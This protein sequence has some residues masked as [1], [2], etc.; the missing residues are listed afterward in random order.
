[1]SGDLSEV[2]SAEPGLTLNPGL[3]SAC[4]E[5][6]PE[7]MGPGAKGRPRH[8]QP[9]CPDATPS[10]GRERSRTHRVTDPYADQ[11]FQEGSL[12]TP[13]FLWLQSDGFKFMALH[14][15]GIGFPLSRGHGAQ[16]TGLVPWRFLCLPNTT[17][18]SR[19]SPS[20]QNQ[21]RAND[22]LADH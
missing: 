5:Q 4:L 3:D 22:P 21:V 15:S 11:G 2:S 9:K 7:I 14:I 13:G 16:G 12:E 10:P 17:A 18:S 6:P 1:M 19:A 20:F 8:R